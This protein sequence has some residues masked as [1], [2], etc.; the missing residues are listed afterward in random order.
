VLRTNPKCTAG[1]AEIDGGLRA[2]D[3]SGPLMD[4]EDEALT[5]VARGKSA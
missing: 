5:W 2:D 4:R 1:S 3:A